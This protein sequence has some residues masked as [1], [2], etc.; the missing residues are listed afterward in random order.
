M[1]VS[2]K[3]F[4]DEEGDKIAEDITTSIAYN[5]A[6]H[7][8]RVDH[9]RIR[10]GVLFENI[11]LFTRIRNATKF[12]VAEWGLTLEGVTVQE[13]LLDNAHGKYAIHMYGV[14][15]EDHDDALLC[16]LRAKG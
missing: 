8:S 6:T 13:W 11:N 14:F 2:I 3:S 1:S 4:S 9:M 7:M 10:H 12:N 5:I 15:F 16:Y